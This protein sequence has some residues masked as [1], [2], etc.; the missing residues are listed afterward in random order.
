MGVSILLVHTI[1]PSIYC[2]ALTLGPIFRFSILGTRTGSA[3][4]FP[5]FRIRIC[6]FL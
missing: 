2:R 1:H 4:L 3:V 6:L 5:S